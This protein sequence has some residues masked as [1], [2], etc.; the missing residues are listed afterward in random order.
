MITRLK[1]KKGASLAIVFIICFV[2]ALL[3]FSMVMFVSNY[4][5]KLDARRESLRSSVYD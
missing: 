2:I 3:S 4:S 5:S 1:T